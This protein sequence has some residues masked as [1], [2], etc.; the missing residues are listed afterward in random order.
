[1]EGSAITSSD[2]GSGFIVSLLD[3]GTTGTL[4]IRNVYGTFADTNTVTSG[5][6]T[7]TISGTPSSYTKNKQAP[8]GSFAG[9]QFFGARGVWL[10]NVAGA[11]ANNYVL[12]DSTGTSQS[13]PNT[14][15][16][17]VNGVL[18][19]DRVSVFRALDDAGTID[20]TYIASHAT[21]NSAS[22]TT[23]T[24]VSIPTDTPSVGFVR[25]RNTTTQVE[26]RIAYT[27]RTSTTFTLSEAH[28]GGYGVSDTA[29]VPYI[30]DMVS[31]TSI[32]VSV[33]FDTTRYIT[34][35]VRK[36]GI[37]PFIVNSIPLNSGGY[38][39]T[40]VRIDDNIA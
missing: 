18:S 26:E 13:P 14:V 34:T 1:V 11:D 17:S 31:G 37:V 38:S 32:S 5:S 27:G 9:G 10:D 24:A 2:G 21:S 28:M 23:W 4:T 19:G 39:A 20:K 6:T 8:F 40:A 30:D 22:S 16:I 15:L 25:L 33:T 12:I 29:Y 3:N 35:R 7:A 36:K